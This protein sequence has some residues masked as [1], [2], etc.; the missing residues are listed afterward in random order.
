MAIVLVALIMTHAEATQRYAAAAYVIGEMIG[1]LTGMATVRS[2]INC[3]TA[4]LV[5]QHFGGIQ[6]CR[7]AKG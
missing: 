1:A 3:F 2:D 5:S 6:A 7:L 4:L